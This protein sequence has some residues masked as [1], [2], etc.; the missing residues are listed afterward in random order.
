MEWVKKWLDLRERPV[1]IAKT[2]RRFSWMVEVARQ[3]PVGILHPYMTEVYMTKD[4]VGDVSLPKP[5][6]GVLRTRR[7]REGGKAG[8]GV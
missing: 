4:G 1:E 8:A 7:S 3:R 6:K 5:A 2:L